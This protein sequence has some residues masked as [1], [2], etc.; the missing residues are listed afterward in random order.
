MLTYCAICGKERR[1]RGTKFRATKSCRACYRKGCADERRQI[2]CPKCGK[3][4]FIL[5]CMAHNYPLGYC[6]TCPRL[7]DASLP[8]TYDGGYILGV[9]LGD[10]SLVENYH[11]KTSHT[12][13]GLR[14]GAT[15]ENFV[16]K[17]GRAL[18][19][20]TGKKPWVKLYRYAKKGSPNI[21]MP[22]SISQDWT[23]IFWGREWYEKIYPF[24]RL[25]KYESIAA[26]S[27]EFKTGF[28]QGMLDSEG[29]VFEG[30][31]NSTTRSKQPYTDIANKDVR[32]LNVVAECARIQGL[33][34]KVY[35]PY[36]YARGVAHLRIAARLEKTV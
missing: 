32:L 12:A 8:D 34:A 1:G 7:Y 9:M 33:K 29:Y 16:R 15:S 3:I 31:T 14:L 10:G 6:R 24:K 26:F 19:V 35:G 18:T 21:S 2:T 30:K 20:C 27:P 5:R 36:P 28:L 11:N 23:L 17:F 13:Y 4:R 22:N 25:K